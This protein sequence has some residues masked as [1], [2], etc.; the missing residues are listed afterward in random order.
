VGSHLL[1]K[2]RARPSLLRQPRLQCERLGILRGSPHI[3]HVAT[4][5]DAGIDQIVN[6]GPPVQ[7]LLI[8]AGFYAQPFRELAAPGW[9]VDIAAPGLRPECVR[10]YLSAW[11]RSG[12]HDA[13]EVVAIGAPVANHLQVA[14]ECL[15]EGVDHLFIETPI[16]RRKR[17]ASSLMT[18]AGRQIVVSSN[19]R[20]AYRLPDYRWALLDLISR[21]A[22]ASDS[23][24][25]QAVAV[26]GRVVDLLDVAYAINGPIR[27]S[28]LSGRRCA[29]Q[30]DVQHDN[31]ASTYIEVNWCGRLA[32][33]QRALISAFD[34]GVAVQAL[35]QPLSL[36]PLSRKEAAEREV[37]HLL[38]VVLK[39]AK[40]ANTIKDAAHVHSWA[41]ELCGGMG[42]NFAAESGASAF[43]R[44]L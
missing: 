40:P 43:G 22:L 9:R 3:S 41:L 16:V 24:A 32:P 34:D 31:M 13:V 19:L 25:E 26:L 30:L 20:F 10:S 44:L 38:N 8:G 1:C 35:H 18:D 14:A 15:A 27:S 28:Q 12:D 6:Y 39:G 36:K 42:L 37:R 29:Y 2:A 7:A 21:A 17:D 4:P 33:E 5:V 11:R 23:G